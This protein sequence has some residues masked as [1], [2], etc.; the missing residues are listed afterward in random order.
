MTHIALADREPLRMAVAGSRIPSRAWSE[1]QDL[2]QVMEEARATL[3]E[4]RASAKAIRE[5]AYTEGYAEG[6]S[7]AQRAAARHLLDAQ[8][9]AQEF[10]EASQQ[11]IVALALGILDRI[12]P[13]LNQSELVT[14]MVLEALSSFTGE[15]SVRVFVAPG[16]VA[17]TE[18]AVVEWQREHARLEAPRVTADPTLEV[19]GCVVESEI[20][21][22]EAGLAAQLAGVRE[23]L[24]AI[25]AAS[26]G[27]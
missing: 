18:A 15:Q 5:K 12:A 7:R 23:A 20:G 14:S 19:F 22:I 17:A 6:A 11:R 13:R 4:A 9:A 24:T 27:K 25:A 21:R 3:A 8:R 16:A 1:V 10:V 2:A 26:S